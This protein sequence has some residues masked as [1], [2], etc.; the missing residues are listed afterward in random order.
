[1]KIAKEA[2]AAAAGAHEV[3][4]ED[5]E[6]I[7]RF[8]KKP[9]TAEEVYVFDM[10][11]C[12][13]D[14]DRDNE[15]F[16]TDALEGLAPLFVG[17]TGIFDHNWTAEGQ[18]G[19]IF[20]T[21]L[22]TDGSRAS[23]SGEPYAYL[24]ASAYILRNEENR[25][26]IADIE[27]GIKREISV[28]CSMGKAVCSICGEETS[29]ARCGHVR[30][31][32]YDGRTCYTSLEEPKDA[33]EWSFVAV[34][35]QKNAG[36]LKGFGQPAGKD[37]LKACVEAAG[38][39]RAAQELAELEKLA[40]LGARHLQDRR[41]E[42]VRLGVLC[43]MGFEQTLLEKAAAGMDGE[44]VEAFIRAFSA[45]ADELLPVVCQLGRKKEKTAFT[46]NEYFI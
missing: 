7:N 32:V 24:K 30:G 46:G 19:R 36:V 11:L 26:L 34:P 28:G 33:Y 17:K 27:G 39:S 25:P 12:D 31:A 29:S 10:L 44:T 14:I 3:S 43:D 45:R 16:S 42:M 2:A 5:L 9:L 40:A 37:T 18:V 35:A 38:G 4:A 23:I 13:N 21:E 1:M 6:A 22:V 15:R 20:R 8:A 41:R